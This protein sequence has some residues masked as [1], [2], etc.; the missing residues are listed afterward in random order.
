VDFMELS[1]LLAI[2]DGSIV[3]W[4]NIRALDDRRHR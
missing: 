2:W 3:R 4:Q 1:E